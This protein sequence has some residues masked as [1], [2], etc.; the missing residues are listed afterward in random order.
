MRLNFSQVTPILTLTLLSLQLLTSCSSEKPLNQVE[1]DC[2]EDNN[3]QRC[4]NDENYYVQMHSGKPNLG[5]CKPNISP[6]NWWEESCLRET[7]RLYEAMGK[8]I[9]S[10]AGA[11]PIKSLKE[12]H[13]SLHGETGSFH[14][15]AGVPEEV[16]Q[17]LIGRKFL[18]PGA[19]YNIQLNSTGEMGQETRPRLSLVLGHDLGNAKFYR[20]EF[21]ASAT[22]ALSYCGRDWYS[23][24]DYESLKDFTCEGDFV[25]SFQE[26][27]YLGVRWTLE[28]YKLKKKNY[29]DWYR[30]EEEVLEKRARKRFKE[31]LTEKNL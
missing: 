27:P 28:A 24:F 30:V 4:L 1:R 25:F 23:V 22:E 19:V 16:A 9:G 12:I 8:W 6:Q 3:N 11:K 15:L 2:A 7:T 14:T 31:Y 10:P 13:N 21:G 5:L 18:I 29:D 26:S 17:K 20:W